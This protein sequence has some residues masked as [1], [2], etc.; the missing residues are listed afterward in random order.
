MSKKRRRLSDDDKALWEKTASTVTPMEKGPSLVLPTR[1]TRSEPKVNPAK[2]AP[3]PIS[4]F[5]IGAKSGSGKSVVDA[6]PSLADQF[7]SA[8]LAMDRKTFQTLKRGKK[9]PEARIDLHGMTLAQAQPALFRFV[10]DAH[11]KGLRLVLV[12]TGKGKD[13]DSCGPIPERLGALRHQVPQWLSGG[14]M[15][16]MVLQI[17]PAHQKHGGGGAYYVYLRRRR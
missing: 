8:P 11:A 5:K 13:R 3:K 6:V 1:G 12:I 10:S 17:T 16:S 4:P 7:S 9:N 15:A 14:P 2:P